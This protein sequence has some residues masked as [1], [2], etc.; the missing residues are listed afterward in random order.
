MEDITR[1]VLKYHP[2]ANIDIIKKDPNLEVPGHAN[3]RQRLQHTLGKHMDLVKI[4]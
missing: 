4:I 2:G 1:E 3:L